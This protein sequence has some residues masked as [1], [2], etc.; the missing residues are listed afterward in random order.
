MTDLE[1]AIAAL[2]EIEKWFERVI[3]EAPAIVG[4]V[5]LELVL[6]R[7]SQLD[8]ILR[9]LPPAPAQGKALEWMEDDDGCWFSKR[10]EWF[11]Q[12]YEDKGFKLMRNDY[13]EPEIG[14]FTRTAGELKSLAQRLQNVLD[15]ATP[16][17][18]QG[19]D[20]ENARLN[21]LLLRFPEGLTLEA[22]IREIVRHY[23]DDP[24]ASF[25]TEQLRGRIDA[26]PAPAQGLT[27][28][29]LDVII[30]GVRERLRPEQ[31]AVGLGVMITMRDAIL[32]T[33]GE[34]EPV[35]CDHEL[36]RWLDPNGDGFLGRK[37][38]NKHC[39]KCGTPLAQATSEGEK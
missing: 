31:L 22:T 19:K 9:A 8:A 14:P 3:P 15:G 39:P 34:P 38:P 11:I 35:E 32:A 1:Q 26:T 28:E 25:L 30:N 4:P 23:P 13:D 16:E 17:P 29:K 6:T 20:L 21:D 27:R 12:P 2:G 7:L 36:M 5:S 33:T 24:Y 10:G 18:A 37:V